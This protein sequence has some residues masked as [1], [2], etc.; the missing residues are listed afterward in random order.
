MEI[1][2]PNTDH[3]GWIVVAPQGEIDVAAAPRLRE[4]LVELTASGT[5]SLVIDLD[6]IDFIDSTGLGVLVGALRRS[7]AANGDVRL[8]CSNPRILKVFD[9]T[10]LHKV[11]VVADTVDD[12]IA[13]TPE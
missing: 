13:A 9:I 3:D 11:F 2:V 12:A 5:T 7:R 10:G 8:V 1:D 6:N 4:R